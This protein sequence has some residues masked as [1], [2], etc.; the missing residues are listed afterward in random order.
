MQK[1]CG[2]KL[3][4]TSEASTPYSQLKISSGLKK[5]YKKMQKKFKKWK[6][7]NLKLNTYILRCHD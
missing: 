2:K 1:S 7:S 3:T 4:C 6:Q 5:M